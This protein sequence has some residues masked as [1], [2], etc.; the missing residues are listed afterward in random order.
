MIGHRL[1]VESRCV[2]D[3]DAPRRGHREIDV[4][5]S[6]T[7]SAN[8]TQLGCAGQ[9]LGV[10][11]FRRPDQNSVDVAQ[12]AVQVT[13]RNG[14]RSR[15]GESPRDGVELVP[16]RIR[17]VIQ[18]DGAQP[19]LRNTRHG[20]L[21]STIPSHPHMRLFRHFASDG[22]T[23]CFI[24]DDVLRPLLAHRTAESRGG[25]TSCTCAR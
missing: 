21:P 25:S 4:V 20:L 9:E 3:E 12:H 2:A 7:D 19:L 10:Q 14:G 17:K 5:D 23:R 13:V 11:P 22:Q 18:G 16:D 1:H 24:A 6:G 8:H 15:P